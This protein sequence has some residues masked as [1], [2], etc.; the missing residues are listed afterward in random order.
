VHYE[1][2]SQGK[3]VNHQYPVVPYCV[4]GKRVVKTNQKWNSVGEFLQHE[5][6]PLILLV[7]AQ[8]SGSKQNDR[9][10]THLYSSDKALC[11]VFLFP[12]T[13]IANE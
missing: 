6:H 1:F 8:V 4:C 7:C 2:V 3:T 5:T 10:S 13:K 9:N 11:D 12:E